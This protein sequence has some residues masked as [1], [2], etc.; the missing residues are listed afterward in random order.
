MLQSTGPTTGP[1]T[2]P[3]PQI[4][5]TAACSSRG[6]VANTIAW[7]IG[8][9]TAPHR[10][11]RSGTASMPVREAGQ[12]ESSHSQFFFLSHDQV[13][14]GATAATLAD[15]VCGTAETDSLSEESRFEPLVPLAVKTLL[16]HAF[17]ETLAVRQQPR[18]ARWRR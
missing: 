7:P 11:C 2:L 8:M 4:T 5:M 15:N 13:E 14:T 17:P 1:T 16:G 10:L 18:E 3:K 6:N 9:I 12:T